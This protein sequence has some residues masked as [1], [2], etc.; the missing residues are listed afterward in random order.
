[1]NVKKLYR[2]KHL[3]ERYDQNY[4]TADDAARHGRMKTYPT[5]CGFQL[6]TEEAFKKWIE[7]PTGGRGRP[8]IATY[9]SEA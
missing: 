1:M 3:C 6:T 4:K 9:R 8:A 5:A 7:R 2:I